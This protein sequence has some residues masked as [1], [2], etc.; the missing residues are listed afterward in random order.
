MKSAK[1]IIFLITLFLVPCLVS[2]TAD[3]PKTTTN[4]K[5]SSDKSEKAKSQPLK[6]SYIK[7]LTDESIKDAH[8]LLPEYPGAQIDESKGSFSKTDM[9]ESYNLVYHTDDSV[10]DVVEFFHSKISEDYLT[11]TSDPEGNSWVHMIFEVDSL[12]HRGSIFVRETKEG[13]TEIIYE[14]HIEPTGINEGK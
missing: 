7:S 8:I 9:G 13:P 2:C 11:Q 1:T 6:Q 12:N 10:S 3:T 14:L 5:T 4:G